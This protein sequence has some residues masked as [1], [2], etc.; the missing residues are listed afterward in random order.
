MLDEPFDF[1]R[2]WVHKRSNGLWKPQDFYP[3]HVLRNKIKFIWKLVNQQKTFY[4]M[5]ILIKPKIL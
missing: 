1:E 4:G 5:P 3:F 2:Q